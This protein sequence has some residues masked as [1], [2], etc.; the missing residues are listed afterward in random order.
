MLRSLYIAATGM[1]AQKL[2]MDVIANNM[3][4]V[5]TVGFK[6]SKAAFQDLM[7]QNLLAPGTTS[8]QDFVVPSGIQVGLGVKPIAVEKIFTQGD[9]VQTGN[10][11]DLVIQG[12]GF[13]QITMPDGT[14][15][16]TRA[17]AFQL[18]N[19]GQIVTADGYTLIPTMAV[20]SNT[21]NLTVGTDGKITV[22]QQGSTKTTQLGQIQLANF[23]NPAG[24]SA[25]G[26]NLFQPTASSGDPITGN[27]GTDGLGTIN[28]GY[29]EMSNVN[30]V[31]EMVNMIISQ[32]AYEINEK[33]IESSDEM[34]QVTNAIKK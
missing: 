14:T 24:L 15:A 7:Y 1:E 10:T 9:F 4:N 23:I 27:A 22:T 3:A 17:G 6:K 8:A 31:E 13:F 16:Y 12:S 32:R 29:T 26:Q 11:L 33:A 21:L 5:N 28:Q 34:L 18:N 30:V 19:T 25:L 20:P 2:N